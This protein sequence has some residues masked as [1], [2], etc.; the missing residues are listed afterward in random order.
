MKLQSLHDVFVHKVQDLYDAERQITQAL[1]KVMEV[2]SSPELKKGMENHLEETRKQIMRLEELC[3]E[4]GIEPQGKTCTGM[5]GVIEESV[6]LM[7]ENVPS[8]ALDAALLAGA[9]MVEHYEI[10]GYGTAAAL[11]KQMNHTNALKLLLQTL[12]EEKAEDIKLSELA[13]TTLNK[14]ADIQQN[15]STYAM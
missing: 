15:R 2:V 6:D 14:E 4:L 13:E 3:K 5:E 1:P 11:A 10:A 8:P 7:Q 9:Q 12:E